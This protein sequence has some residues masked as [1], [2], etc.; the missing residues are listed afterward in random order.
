[1]KRFAKLLSKD[2]EANRLPVLFLAGMILILMAYARFKLA[3]YPWAQYHLFYAV[4]LPAGFLPFWLIWQS[5]Q[6]LRSEWREDTVYTLLVLPVSGWQV[7]LAKLV[8]ICLEYTFLFWVITGGTWLFFKNVLVELWTFV[9]DSLWLVWNLF[10]LYAAGLLGVAVLVIYVQ[11]GFVVSKLVGRLQAL[12]AL[13]VWVLGAWLVDRVGLLL[14]PLLGWLPSISVDRLLGWERVHIDLSV[15]LNL[16]PPVG[17]GLALVGLFF[18]AG[19]LFEH[20]LEIN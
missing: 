9:P 17:A 8:S 2:L 20:Y 1:M 11:L 6:T 12:V 18:L 3:Q 16:A 15:D 10:W 13:W 5:F 19:Y 4:A 14:Q 7:L